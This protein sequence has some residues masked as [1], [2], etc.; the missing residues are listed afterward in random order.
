MKSHDSTRL[1][2][3][4]IRLCAFA[5]RPTRLCM[6]PPHGTVSTHLLRSCGLSVCVCHAPNLGAVPSQQ[7]S[8]WS[9]SAHARRAQRAPATFHP[10]RVARR[11]PFRTFGRG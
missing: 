6:H 5:A 1:S 9:R 4:T 7:A 2:G 8:P 10:P 3:S 11:L